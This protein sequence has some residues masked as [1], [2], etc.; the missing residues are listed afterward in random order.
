MRK[1]EEQGGRKREI[2]M[3]SDKESEIEDCGREVKK[4]KKREKQ[5]KCNLGKYTICK[6]NIR[7]SNDL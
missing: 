3:K 2:D 1:Y 7:Y 5:I 6:M 4:E